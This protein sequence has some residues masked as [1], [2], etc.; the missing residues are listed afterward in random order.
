MKDLFKVSILDYQTN[1]QPENLITK[2]RRIE[3]HGYISFRGHAA[4]P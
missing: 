4:A 2:P 3:G 1:N